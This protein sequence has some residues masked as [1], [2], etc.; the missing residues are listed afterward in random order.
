M[1]RLLVFLPLTACGSYQPPEQK[2]FPSGYEVTQS[3]PAPVPSRRINAPQNSV[4]CWE[5]YNGANRTIQCANGYW[6]TVTKDG[7]V[8]DGNGT[9]DPNEGANGSSIVI[10]PATGGPNTGTGPSVQAPNA[11]TNGNLPVLAPYQGPMY[12]YPL[13][14]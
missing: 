6:Q 8:Y 13:P 7:M 5:V 9:F 10:N 2:V 1:K 3:A 4:P 11:S 14:E 12:G